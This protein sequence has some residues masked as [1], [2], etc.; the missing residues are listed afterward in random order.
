MRSLVGLIPL[1]ATEII[2]KEELAPFRLFNQNFHWFME[3][4]QDLIQD[5]IFEKEDLYLFSLVNRKQLTDVLRYV[6]NPEEFRSPYGL[7]SLSKFHEKHPFSF[8]EWKVGYEPGHSLTK[9]KGG[10][11]NW[12]GPI[13][14]PTT[15]LFI[16]A[17]KKFSEVYKEEIIIQNPQEP[18]VDIAE[19]AKGFRE[20]L[21]SLFLPNKEGFRPFW[22]AQFP[23]LHDPHWM[24]HL[25]FYEYYHA[26]TGQGLGA[27][28]HTGWNALVAN[29]ISER[30]K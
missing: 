26:E 10:N 2:K 23:Y 17:L 28:H 19:I 4:K 6:W 5:C 3:K 30:R 16:E 8:Q 24:S 25:L 1:Y 21:I 13:W 29:L 27:S 20:R 22:G 11:S 18:P 15:Y 7:R 12:R 14:M 9:I